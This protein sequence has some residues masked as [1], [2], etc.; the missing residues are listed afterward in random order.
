MLPPGYVDYELFCQQ[1]ANIDDLHVIEDDC[2]DRHQDID[3]DAIPAYSPNNETWQAKWRPTDSH[4]IPFH[5]HE[6][7][8][9]QP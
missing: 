4:D 5:P 2:N 1:Q 6:L 7:N 9:P 3:D 8:G